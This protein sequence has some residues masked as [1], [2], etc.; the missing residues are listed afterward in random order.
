M[1]EFSPTRQ[2]FA[3]SADVSSASVAEAHFVFKRSRYNSF[4]LRA[5]CGRDVRAPSRSSARF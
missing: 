4:A 2:A 1:I 5:H 3:G